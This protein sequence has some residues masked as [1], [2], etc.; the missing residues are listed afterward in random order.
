F[1]R[2]VQYG[3]KLVWWNF[4][5]RKLLVDRLKKLESS[6]SMTRKLLRFGKSV[7]FIQAALKTMHIPDTLIRWTVTLSKLS[8]A[9]FLIFDH[10]IYFHNLGVINSDKKKWSNISA[11]FWLFSLLLNLIRNFYDIIN[12][13]QH[14]IKVR[15]TMKKKSQYANGDSYHNEKTRAPPGNLALVMK[16]MAE[17]KPV[18]LDLL[19]NLSDLVLPL[20]TL[21]KVNAS[22]GMQGLL[23]LISSGIGIVT[24]WNPL[25]KLVPS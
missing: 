1:F 4:Q 24:V 8:Q 20:N 16:G 22:P 21:E 2:F 10:I 17:N 23:G 18:V 13:V 19:K 3:S 12:I 5:S 25:L 14:E 6:M 7:D 15:E 11:Q 9:I